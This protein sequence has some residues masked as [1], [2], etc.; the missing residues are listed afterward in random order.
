MG[1]EYLAAKID[2]QNAEKSRNDWRG[3]PTSGLSISRIELPAKVVEASI[4]FM[5]ALG[6]V[7]GSFD[8]AVTED[9]E[10]VFFEINEQGQFLW[11]EEQCPDMPCLQMFVDFLLSRN[12]DFQWKGMT[13]EKESLTTC[14]NSDDYIELL[15]RE[16]QHVEFSWSGI[17]NEESVET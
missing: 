7:T 15:R 11:M 5:D 14:L 12:V 4:G 9:D 8:F 10:Y 6:V 2:S 17:F 1:R 13:N 3:T 16:E